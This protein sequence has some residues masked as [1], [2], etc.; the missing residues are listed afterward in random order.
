MGA[1][2][3]NSWSVP[4]GLSGCGRRSGRTSA[5]SPSQLRQPAFEVFGEQVARHSAAEAMYE[6]LLS[7]MRGQAL[8]YAL[9]P[10]APREQFLQYWPAINEAFTRPT[11]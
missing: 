8:T 5:G 1:N 6:V 10:D 11:A 4:C 3:Q 2:L 7:S 9:Q